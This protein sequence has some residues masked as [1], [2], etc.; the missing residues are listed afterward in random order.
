[1]NNAALNAAK[2][3]SNS[4]EKNSS[5]KSA[6]KQRTS[7]DLL[8]LLTHLIHWQ[9]VIIRSLTSTLFH[10]GPRIISKSTRT[11]KQTTP[12]HA[13]IFIVS[14]VILGRY[15]FPKR[16][17]WSWLFMGQMPFLS[18]NLQHQTLK[19]RNR[20]LQCRPHTMPL[21]CVTVCHTINLLFLSDNVQTSATQK[22]SK[23][24]QML[25]I[26]QS[27]NLTWSDEPV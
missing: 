7:N 8:L 27:N 24:Q 21:T 2:Q 4:L 23:H 12:T 22:E 3:L 13:F 17:N 14:G 10:S 6:V 15:T 1:M 25:K 26:P 5:N 11:S 19:G 16:I 9:G 20:L 18:T